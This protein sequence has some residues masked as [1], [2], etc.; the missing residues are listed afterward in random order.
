MEKIS[1]LLRSVHV[2]KY[3][4][5]PRI[6][7]FVTLEHISSFI[8]YK[9]PTVIILTVLCFWGLAWARLSSQ[10]CYDKQLAQ[11]CTSLT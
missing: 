1:C 2:D 11:W 10:L 8:G 6:I 4:C 5:T 9:L 7:V 3:R